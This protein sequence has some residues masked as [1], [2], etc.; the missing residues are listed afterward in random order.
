MPIDPKTTPAYKTLY[1]KAAQAHQ[2]WQDSLKRSPDPTSHATT[3]KAWE[4]AR[5]NMNNFVV[6]PPPELTKKPAGQ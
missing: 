3:Q 2:N 5:D 1:D 4:T 6:T